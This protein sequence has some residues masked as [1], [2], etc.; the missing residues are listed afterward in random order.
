MA[1]NGVGSVVEEALEVQE[2]WATSCRC[3]V[4]QLKNDDNDIFS[5]AMNVIVEYLWDGK[6]REDATW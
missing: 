2:R 4:F 6:E 3:A 1:E 5:N